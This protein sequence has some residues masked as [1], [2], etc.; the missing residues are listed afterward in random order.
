MKTGGWTGF[1]SRVVAG[2][3]VVVMVILVVA[4]QIPGVIR[5]HIESF[6]TQEL[7]RPVTVTEVRINLPG[8][9]LDIR[10]VKIGE[11]FSLERA[12]LELDGSS[13]WQQ[14]PVFRGVYLKRP[15]LSLSRDANGKLDIDD[16]LTRWQS[17]P[18]S[19]PLP[20]FS[21]SN[22]VVEGGGI[23]F[24]DD[25]LAGVGDYRLDEITLSVPRIAHLGAG[26][27]SVVEPFFSAKLNGTPLALEGKARPF[28]EKKAAEFRLSIN[29]LDL[30]PWWPL[31]GRVAPDM[32]LM[33]K[34]GV[35]K[36]DLLLHYLDSSPA[37]EA[38][39]GLF[40]VAGDLSLGDF[41]AASSVSPEQ[42]DLRFSRLAV[43]LENLQPLAGIY[44][45]RA[46]E[47]RE[48]RIRARRLANG[49]L[50]GWPASRQ[51]TSRGVQGGQGSSSSVAEHTGS[52]WGVG[53]LSILGGQMDL[54]D[55]S[56]HP[57]LPVKIRDLQLKARSLGSAPSEPATF[58]A[59]VG[60]GALPWLEIPSL[61]IKGSFDLNKK[62]VD[63]EQINL[64]RPYLEG[65][66]ARDGTW[67][68]PQPVHV[69]ASSH[70]SPVGVRTGNA[71]ATSSN[72]AQQKE[73]ARDWH[74]QLRDGAS[75]ATVVRSVP[76]GGKHS[77]RTPPASPSDGW[78]WRVGLIQIM[79]GHVVFEDASRDPAQSPS[80]SRSASQKVNEVSLSVSGLRSD[81]SVPLQIGLHARVNQQGMIQLDGR[82]DRWATSPSVR[83]NM[84]WKNIELLPFRP[85]FADYFNVVFARG[86]WGGQGIVE[87]DWRGASPEEA[88]PGVAFTGET[89]LADLDWIDPV[90][91]TD[92]LKWKSL[93]VG[94]IRL[95]AD[96][97]KPLDLSIRQIALSDFYSRLILGSDG[98][99]NISGMIKK[100]EVVARD[101]DERVSSPAA[102]SSERVPR[103]RVDQVTLH[104]GRVN[105][106]DYFVKPNYSV[107]LTQLAG[108]ALGLSSEEGTEARLDIKGFVDDQAP[109]KI[110]GTL[111]PL[112]KEISLDIKSDI[113]GIELTSLSTYSA[114]Y[115]GY[116]IERGKLS[117]DV[118]YRIREGQLEANNH[119][120]IDQ[121]TFGDRV[122]SP[123]ATSLPVRLAVALLKN[124]RGEIDLDLPISGSLND[125]EFSVGGLVFRM[126]MNL[127]MK[128]VTSPFA[129]LSSLFDGQDVA[130]YT[131]FP[132]GEALVTGESEGALHKVVKVMQERPEL[133]MDVVGFIDPVSDREGLRKTL[134]LRRVKAFKVLDRVKKGLETG[135]IDE[136]DLTPEEY[137]IFL[138]QAYK[139]ASFPKPRNIVGLIKEL[140]QDEMEQLLE[141]HQI[142][143]EYDLAELGRRRARHVHDW[144]IRN[145]GISSERVFLV[146]REGQGQEAQD[147]SK[148]KPP[149]RV[150]F[151]LK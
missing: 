80:V 122:E 128:V 67:A 94:G 42:M 78:Q 41:H 118:A 116:N 88:T 4:W 72:D 16:L 150:E 129:L 7:S 48:P 47:L 83:L 93:F 57:A 49:Q 6:L 3:M 134:L 110:A 38:G 86:R 46:V 85:Y 99:L 91:S 1:K 10:G 137:L 113:K 27:E 26:G 139:D 130:S 98:R 95:R 121:L 92:F 35:L 132:P 52:S 62:I 60:I 105:F 146:Q 32:P 135:S 117:F 112:A 106:S 120:F 33:L 140:P 14:A 61:Q 44:Q 63:I 34:S 25:F 53:E 20:R 2:L 74:R 123:D 76:R 12:L 103:I 133:K 15:R 39:G 126:V 70:S 50:A 81:R 87:L 37:P 28:A 21:L 56:F 111:N 147:D 125:P 141:S 73:L 5:G 144:L 96:P 11:T 43:Q 75:G 13:L 29:E 142:V 151:V 24:R 104:R 82:V 68:V 51:E 64:D 145:G 18:D 30:A 136:V 8:L 149:A 45:I 23:F 84:V 97:D 79:G 40:R 17:E 66:L 71:T 138:R 114:K 143:T 90:H 19:G 58:D 54:K 119:L 101:N 109:A 124:S 102:S 131:V 55:E 100:S 22:L 108:S 59:T 31:V 77:S 115:A 9:W 127:L 148:T 36:A 107:N 89:S 69:P 65:H